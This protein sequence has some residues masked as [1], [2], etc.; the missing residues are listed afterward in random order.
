VSTQLRPRSPRATPS[1]RGLELRHL[2]HFVTVA[3]E[4]H[5]R[6]AADRLRVSQPAVT[7][8]VR[9]LEEE[10][11]VRLFDRT[12]RSVSLTPAGDAFL[13]EARRV[14]DLAERAQ[15]IALKVGEHGSGRLRLGLLADAVP[16]AL[17]RTLARCA[18]ETPCV[19]VALDTCPSLELVERVRNRELDA[20]VVCLPAPVSGLRVTPLGE[21]G[22]VVGLGETH[23]AASGL[24]VNPCHLEHRPLLVMAR[25]TNPAFFDGLVEAWRSAGVA[26]TPVEV[27][28]PNVEHLLLAAAAGAGAAVVPESAAR[29]FTLPG[30]R[31]V[32]LSRPSPTFEVV[33]ISRPEHSSIALTAFLR[34]VRAV[35][36]LPR[37]MHL[38]GAVAARQPASAALSNGG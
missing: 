26:A 16:A 20:A 7:E 18:A 12:N 19:E 3:E 13:P 10:L 29:R 11:G 4:L 24:V 34:L 27:A 33:V 30:V 31:F 15:R 28:V 1:G 2:R 22:V 35:S 5:F 17:P 38:A 37:E 6:R 8:Q 14:L 32:R 21:E 25:T 9:K 23:P 36:T